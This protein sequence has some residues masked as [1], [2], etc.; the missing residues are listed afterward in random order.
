MKIFKFL[1]FNNKRNTLTVQFSQIG[2]F[3]V[4]WLEKGNHKF[5]FFARPLNLTL[6]TGYCIYDRDKKYSYL[7]SANGYSRCISPFKF[8]LTSTWKTAVLYA[9]TKKKII[10]ILPL[11]ATYKSLPDNE[12]IGIEIFFEHEKVVLLKLNKDMLILNKSTSYTAMYFNSGM[13]EEVI[14]I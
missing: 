14:N 11:F 12:M 10:N 5:Y 13:L 3:R 6:C 8:F 9:N 7:W 1:L 2:T 4:K